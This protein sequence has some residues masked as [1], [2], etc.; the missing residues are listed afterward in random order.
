MQYNWHE[1]SVQI[2]AVTIFRSSKS[3]QVFL[4]KVYPHWPETVVVSADGVFPRDPKL[5][6]LVLDELGKNENLPVII[7]GSVCAENLQIASKKKLIMDEFLNRDMYRFDKSEKVF[8]WNE[9]SI[10]MFC[11]IWVLQTQNLRLNYTDMRDYFHPESIS[12]Y[13]SLIYE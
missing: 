6:N 11:S 5:K 2:N 1:T 4:D 12:W 7:F 3:A 9:Y 10:A 8:N 13:N